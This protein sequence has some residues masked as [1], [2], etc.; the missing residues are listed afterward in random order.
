MIE[1]KKCLHFFANERKRRSR[2]PAVGSKIIILKDLRTEDLFVCLEI[3]YS[4]LMVKNSSQNGSTHVVVIIIL[5]VALIGVL[6]YILWTNFLAP[7]DEVSQQVV[8]SS[9][10]SSGQVNEPD[11][12]YKDWKS[13]K[14][15]RE[16]L[17]F[18]YPATWSLEDNSQTAWECK[19][20]AQNCPDKSIDI[21]NLSSTTG[22]QM[23]ILT[24]SDF[25]PRVKSEGCPA[26]MDACNQYE[27]ESI[28]VAGKQLYMVI[29]GYK[30]QGVSENFTLG[31]TDI[32]DCVL[33]C[34]EG[35]GQAKNLTGKIQVFAT[36]PDRNTP[37]YESFKADKSVQEA[38]LV[39][40][41]LTY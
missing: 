20:N 16:G 1:A 27:Q 23:G 38:K 37:T 34:R 33:S 25:T 39:I 41:S 9:K 24:G 30:Q 10:D 6:G 40:Q 21:V 35:L 29:T 15:E 3:T 8:T 12:I 2:C 14:L 19:P 28:T 17:S 18:R 31:L 22:L 5:V 4:R 7:K 32:D 36:Y 13:Y 11:D 26:A